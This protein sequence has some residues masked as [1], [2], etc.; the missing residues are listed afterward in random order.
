MLA[1]SRAAAA[2]PTALLTAVLARLASPP[3]GLSAVATA[4]ELPLSAPPSVAAGGDGGPRA[5]SGRHGDDGGRAALCARSKE[6]M[7]AAANGDPAAVA[8]CDAIDGSVHADLAAAFQDEDPAAVP[9]IMDLYNAAI[10]SGHDTVGAAMRVP[11]FPRPFLLVG[12]AE[13]IPPFVGPARAGATATRQGACV[14][15]LQR[16]AAAFPTAPTMAAAPDPAAVAGSSH[17]LALRWEGCHARSIT[18]PT[19]AREV[20]EA[21]GWVRLST[22]RLPQGLLRA[23]PFLSTVG[24]AL[25]GAPTVRAWRCPG[26]A[27]TSLARP[28]DG[29]AAHVAAAHGA[30]AAAK[31]VACAHCPATFAGVPD[32]YRHYC[33]AHDGVGSSAGRCG[34]CR[35]AFPGRWVVCPVCGRRGDDGSYSGG[36]GGGRGSGGGSSGD[37]GR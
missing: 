1:A 26:C 12:L 16:H 18:V 14:P 20:L 17:D 15:L 24:D 30:A 6:L 13:L 25:A 32:L 8:R 36:G 2:P 11:P 3:L 22:V 9:C 34:G 10:A 4:E 21:V 37:G 35:S 5:S 27:W 31:L 7:E 29:L 33:V 19:T 23:T 28:V